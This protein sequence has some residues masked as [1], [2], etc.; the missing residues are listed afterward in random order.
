MIRVEREIDVERSADEVF[1][2]LTRIEDLPRWQPEISE[3]GLESA[4]PLRVGSRI[5]IVATVAGQRI[6]AT[7]TVTHLERP[8]TI[9]LVANAGSA[10]V[11]GAVSIAATGANACRV[12]LVTA[13]R[14]N[15]LLRFVEGV[16]R[17]RIQ[18]E[19]PA[20]AASVKAWLEAD[21]PVAYDAADRAAG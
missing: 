11:E 20:V 12:G 21:E 14:L 15:G 1:D 13:V 3:A 16:A 2:R 7:G 10:D 8:T 17:S 19:A 5:R 18:A 4:P 9:A 6:V